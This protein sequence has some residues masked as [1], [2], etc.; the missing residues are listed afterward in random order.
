[1]TMSDVARLQATTVTSMARPPGSHC[2]QRWELSPAAK[3][4]VVSARGVP[5][6]SDTRKMPDVSFGAKAI[7]PDGFQLAPHPLGASASVVGVP[8][9]IGAF[10]SFPP[11]KNP[12][13]RPSGEKNGRRAPSVP[14]S[15]RGVR[16]GQRAHVEPR[17]A[18]VRGDVDE[19]PPVGSQRDR[20]FVDAGNVERHDRRGVREFDREVTR[21]RRGAG[22][23]LEQSPGR[24]Q[25][26]GARES[27]P[28]P[29][30]YGPVGRRPRRL[31]GHDGRL[32]LVE[33]EPR[34]ANGAQAFARVLLEAAAQ[35]ATH[36][37]RERCRQRVPRHIVFEHAR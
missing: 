15:A 32:G 13:H 29:P 6:W 33:F 30:G 20:A 4:S 36:V 31:R 11:A 24:D 19:L 37:R 17:A 23:R 28:E 1:M 5:P 25:Q 26:G 3:S 27:G 18:A 34:I 12:T 16:I 35:Q 10:L 8:P 2:G 22:R 7:S 14:G 21:G 9:A